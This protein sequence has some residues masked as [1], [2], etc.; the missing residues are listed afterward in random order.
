M[1]AAPFLP[2]SGRII[3]AVA[4]TAALAA[5]DPLASQVSA[6]GHRDIGGPCN[7]SRVHLAV[8]PSL[9]RTT[10]E[11]TYLPLDF[12]NTTRRGCWLRGYP[13]VFGISTSGTE[14]IKA[15]NLPGTIVQVELWSGYTAHVWV[16]ISH[17]SGPRPAGCATFA[18]NGFRVFPPRTTEHAWVVYSYAGCATAGQPVLAVGPIQQGMANPEAFP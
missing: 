15:V 13:R 7:T 1:K 6:S 16:R 8:D 18:S 9:A 2:R 3:A 4:L 14:Q 5:C 10:S 17:A 11:G 12:I